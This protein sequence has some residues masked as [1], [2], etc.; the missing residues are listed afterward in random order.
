MAMGKSRLRKEL[1]E[2][3]SDLGLLQTR[4]CTEEENEHYRMVLRDYGVLPN[5]VFIYNDGSDSSMARFYT[6]SYT[7]LTKE[8]IA[9]YLT[10][11]QLSCLHTIKKC[12]VF[13][14]VLAIISMVGSLILALSSL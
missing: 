4:Y 14:T 2:Y 1:E 6:I 11:K 3:R 9:E 7:D 13:F 12:V 8:E 5:D 10:Y